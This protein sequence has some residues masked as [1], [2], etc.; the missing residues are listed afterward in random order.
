M[1]NVMEYYGF[2]FSSKSHAS[3][4]LSSSQRCFK[5]SLMAFNVLFLIFGIVLTAV[6]SYALTGNVSQLA[7]QTLPQGITVMGG[8]ILVLSLAGCIAAWKESRLFLAIYFGFLAIFTLILF[9]VGIAVYVEKDKAPEF[10][11]QAWISAYNDGGAAGKEVLVALETQLKCCGLR[12]NSTGGYDYAGPNCTG[13]GS[14][15]DVLITGFQSTYVTAGGCAIA[16][17]IIMVGGMVFVCFLMQGIKRK[18]H[19]EDIRKLHKQIREAKEG[20]E[21]V[22]PPTRLRPS[23]EVDDVEFEEEEV[24]VEEEEYE[25]E[26]A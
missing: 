2:Q 5:Y 24:E 4:D 6:G 8:F 7:G 11:S 3:P 23:V 10:I 25:E 20:G 1:S 26:Q 9:S 12:K 22:G 16:F 19:L 14:C 15:L 18:R 21:P 13:S 17:A